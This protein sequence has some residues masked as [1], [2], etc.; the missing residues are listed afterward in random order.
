MSE[1]GGNPE[2]P[3]VFGAE[4][5]GDAAAKGG[6]MTADVDGDIK[7]FSHDRANEF[8]LRLLNLVVQPAENALGGAGVV[9]LHER[10]GESPP[11]PVA[12]LF[13]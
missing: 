8:S 9:V 10:R 7:D 1:S 11:W 12:R 6:G 4:P 13:H 2:H 3:L 5:Y